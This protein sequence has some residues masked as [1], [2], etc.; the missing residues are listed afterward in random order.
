VSTGHPRS[1]HA[2]SAIIEGRPVDGVRFISDSAGRI[3]SIEHGVRPAGGELSLGT[4]VPGMGNAHSHAFHRLLRGRTHADGGD[5]WQWRTA[6]YQAAASLDPERYY[7]VARAVFGEML[8]CGWTAVGEFHYVHHRHDGRPYAVAHAMESAVASAASDV[9]VRLTLLDTAYLAGGLGAPLLPEQLAF[10]DG[11]AERWLERWYSLRDHLAAT[12]GDSDRIT[13]G[14]A[15][16]SV[17][18][19]PM[20]AMATILAGLPTDVPLH[21]H[22]SEQPQENADTLAATGLTPTGVL[23]ELGALTSRISLVHATHLTDADV[24]LIGSSRATVVMCPTTESDLGDGIGP[25]R[26]LADAGARIAVGSDQ[27]AVIDPFLELR[28]LEAGERLFSGQRGRFDPAALLAAGSAAGYASL[29][30]GAH[31]LSIG[32]PLDLV[33]LSTTSLRTQGSDPAQIAL[34][35]TAADVE[36]VIVAGSVVASS[37][38]LASSTA[39]GRPEHLLAEA[40]A[41]LSPL[42]SGTSAATAQGAHP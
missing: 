6:M 21:V 29:G 35:A 3:T 24:A 11:T 25:A 34:T 39:A 31:T 28:G 15:L 12:V 9:G 13:L 18:A 26:R 27:N 20:D 14:A 19:V 4:V 17:R 2:S 1:I 36:R 32:Q 5:F 37:G 30:L 23:A 22:L 8:V 40:L 41:G 16:H 42:R 7:A 38:T 33:E 10:G